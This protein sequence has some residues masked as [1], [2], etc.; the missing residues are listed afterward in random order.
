MRNRRRFQALTC[1]PGAVLALSLFLGVPLA[2]V[3][4]HRILAWSA[5]TTGTAPVNLVGTYD[6]TAH[7]VDARRRVSG[8]VKESEF[9]DY[10]INHG[11]L[12]VIDQLDRLFRGRLIWRERTELITGALIGDGTQP[13]VTRISINL[14]SLSM[15]G[16]V[17]VAGGAVTIE[18]IGGGWNEGKGT[19][20]KTVAFWSVDLKAV[21]VSD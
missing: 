10:Q 12:V 15:T 7:F 8:G 5:A 13:G 20:S 1:R 3:R 4:D 19:A 16:H 17:K 11:T 18:G 9:G 2:G 14:E 21:K 6:F